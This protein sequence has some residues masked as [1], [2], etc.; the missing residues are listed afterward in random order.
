MSDFPNDLRRCCHEV[1]VEHSTPGSA[2]RQRHPEGL[3]AA[4]VL[5]EIRLKRPD[6]FPLCTWLDVHDEMTA[7][8]GKAPNRTS[9]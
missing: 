6:A 7:L 2:V 9:A 8:Y 4:D 5:D 3:T 1:M